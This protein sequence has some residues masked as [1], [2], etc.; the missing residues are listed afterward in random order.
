MLYDKANKAVHGITMINN[1]VLAWRFD[2]A[3]EQEEKHFKL[4]MSIALMESSRKESFAKTVKEEDKE[5]V[6]KAAEV[7][8]EAKADYKET[9]DYEF[10]DSL[11]PKHDRFSMD[12]IGEAL[13]AEDDSEVE[14]AAEESER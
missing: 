2:F 14:S 10:S 11:P 9:D 7:D 1:T 12:S 8:V 6:T 13:P 5:W 3:D 4:N